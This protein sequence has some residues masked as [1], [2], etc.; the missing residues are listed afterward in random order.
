MNSCSSGV[1][2][3]PHLLTIRDVPHPHRQEPGNELITGT[4]WGFLRV[5]E[6][7]PSQARSYHL[8]T[9]VDWYNTR[10]W[11]AALGY[12]TPMEFEHQHLSHGTPFVVA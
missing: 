6:P 8:T 12:Q 10:Y 1:H 4:S 2:P 11:H 5:F 9:W 7:P 3:F